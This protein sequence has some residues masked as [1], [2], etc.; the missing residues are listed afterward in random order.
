V[1]TALALF[2]ALSLLAWLLALI[3]FGLACWQRSPDAGPLGLGTA[4][5]TCYVIG[6]CVGGYVADQGSHN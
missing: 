6:V 3:T 2:L 5:L 1:R 4:L